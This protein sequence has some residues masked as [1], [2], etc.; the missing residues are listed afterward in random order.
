MLRF[1]DR[2]KQGL[3]LVTGY[4]THSR[5]RRETLLRGIPV[6]FYMTGMSPFV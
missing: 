2:P 3:N 6:Y 1:S 5:L 4:R